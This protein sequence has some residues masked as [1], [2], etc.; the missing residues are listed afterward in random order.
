[1]KVDLRLCFLSLEQAKCG[2]AAV[3]PMKA[4]LTSSTA[5]DP[6]RGHHCHHPSEDRVDNTCPKAAHLQLLDFLTKLK[7][8]A[9]DASFLLRIARTR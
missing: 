2:Q 5:E 3:E 1:M 8:K 6:R 9:G 7:R 4:T